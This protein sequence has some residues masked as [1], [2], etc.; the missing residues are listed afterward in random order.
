MSRFLY[1]Y[2]MRPASD[3][4]RAAVPAHVE[5]W[6]SRNLPEYIGGPF[7]DRTGGLITFA[8]S[9][10]ETARRTVQDDPFVQEDLVA[11]SWVRE[12]QVE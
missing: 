1:F 5:Y 9:S 4:I 10:L 11:D 6:R 3:A 12:W 8:A 7:A 2:R